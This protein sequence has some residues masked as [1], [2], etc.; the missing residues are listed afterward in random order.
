M[1]RRVAG[2]VLAIAILAP[3][4][5]GDD[6]LLC[7][8]FE[9]CGGDPVGVWTIDR[10][11]TTPQRSQVSED[12]DE[13]PDGAGWSHAEYSG[14]WT[15]GADLTY[16]VDGMSVHTYRAT[17][18]LSCPPEGVTCSDYLGLDAG[19]CTQDAGRCECEK[20][21]S[22][23][24]TLTGGSWA[25]SDDGLSLDGEEPS[26]YCATQGWLW[27]TLSEETDIEKDVVLRRPIE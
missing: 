4:C 6:D 10:I 18:P 19:D 20:V 15:F 8:E 9:S 27:M 21:R 12:A 2:P 11:C 26:P 16:E 22:G 5:G 13:C 23:P 17:F 24:F 1:N 14:I 3:A 25:V 7:A